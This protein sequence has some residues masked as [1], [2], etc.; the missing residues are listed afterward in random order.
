MTRIFLNF[1]RTVLQKRLSTA[2]NEGAN[3]NA[4][5]SRGKT[6][7]MS[8]IK[9]SET[10]TVN[11]LL[12]A[13]ADINAKDEDGK[14]TLMYVFSYPH[15]KDD[16]VKILI[17]AGAD[18]NAR[19]EDGDTALMLAAQYA[20]KPETVQLLIKAGADVNAKNDMGYTVLMNA[21]DNSMNPAVQDI[22]AVLLDAG[23]DISVKKG[24]RSA[25]DFAKR[26]G[27]LRNNPIIQRL[28]LPK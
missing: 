28:E 2:L 18:I 7:L 14:T 11:V 9:Y 21:A 8:A 13:G 4:S 10:D 19:N 23:A 22:I 5:D 17:E 20:E 24:E 1:A 16:M 3:V 6:A 25:A 15:S 26:N 12:K 27:N